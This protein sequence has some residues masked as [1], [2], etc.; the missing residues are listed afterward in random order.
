VTEKLYKFM[1]WPEIEAIIYSEH[2]NPHRLLGPH[3]QGSSA[4]VQ[5]YFPGAQKVTVVTEEGKEFAMEMAD[6]EGY[7][8]QLIPGKRLGDYR[9]TVEWEERTESDIMD[10]YRFEPVIT[11]EEAARFNA[12]IH[13]EAYRILGAHLMEAEGVNGVHFAV[14]APNAVRVSVVGDFNRWDGRMHQMRR[15]W[16]SGIFEIFI[17]GL[18]EGELYKFEIK[19]KGNLTWLKADPYAFGQQ[20][21]PD[22]ASVVRDID[23]FIWEDEEWT[24]KR[25]GKDYISEPVSVYEMYLGSFAEAQEGQLY[26][27]YRQLAPKVAAYVQKMG[28]THV[29]LMPVMEHPLDSSLGYQI[30]G[31]YAPTAR[32]GTAQDFMYFV[33]ELHKAGIGVILDWVPAHF[34]KDQHGLSNFDGTCLYEHKDP[35]QGIHPQ[36]G[37]LLYNYG[38]KEVGSY[39]IANALYWIE[40]YH[41]DGLRMDSVASMLYLDYGKEEKE[42]IANIYGGNE[43]LEAV[44]FVRHLNS[45]VKKRNP[46]IMMIAEGS[47]AWPNIT[48]N[49][50]NDGLGF[51]MKW[52]LGWTSD[53]L[54]YMQHDPVSRAY[55]HNDL[56][57]SMIYA[58]SENFMLCLSH[59]EMIHGKA[60]MISKMPGTDEEKFAN[61]KTGYGYMMT[62][63]GKK[64]LFMGQDFGESAEWNEKHNTDWTLLEKTEHKGLQEFVACLNR[65]YVHNPAMYLYDTSWKG[66]DWID[67]IKSSECSIS[68]L[69]RAQTEEQM[70]LICI[71][72]S[73]E[74]R[75]DYRLGVPFDGFYQEILNSDELRFGGKGRINEKTVKAEAIESDGREFSIAI[76]QAPLSVSIFACAPAEE[77]IPEEELVIADVME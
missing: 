6:E 76:R 1:N 35:R 70:L 46:G 16:D 11:K 61:L 56:T 44:E 38:R 53:F 43:N 58:Y 54:H 77:E 19:G 28:Y 41:V 64:L 9:Y 14:W 36:W 20:L 34:P 26:P 69:R 31:Y 65:L 25:H 45:I 37:T 67:C 13:Y 5:C 10:P 62:H 59:D 30:I 3:I 75:I 66:F 42:W 57:F 8:A 47:A 72:F 15:L 24:T 40:H 12:G 52:N 29:E 4:L 55:H 2:D 17:P 23:G 60:S 63:P 22:T 33:N 68:Y 32:Y 21:R 74:D 7:F 27:N 73:N 18:K 71:N 39:L 48:G 49:S 51:T 50:E